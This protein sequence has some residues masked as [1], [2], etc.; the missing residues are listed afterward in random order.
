MPTTVGPEASSHML[1][2]VRTIESE[3]TA[4]WKFAMPAAGTT[5]L[6]TAR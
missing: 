5:L 3:A 4:D 2:A 6:R 1:R